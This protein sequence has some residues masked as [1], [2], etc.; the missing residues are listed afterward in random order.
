[1]L[2]HVAVKTYK[3]AT[4]QMPVNNFNRTLIPKKLSDA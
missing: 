1:L 4:D 2:K 3:R